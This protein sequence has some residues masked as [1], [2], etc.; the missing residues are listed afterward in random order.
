MT[1][2]DIFSRS[3]S[4]STIAFCD[5]VGSDSDQE[6]NISIGLVC[7]SNSNHS[8]LCGFGFTSEDLPVEDDVAGYFTCN[9]GI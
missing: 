2:K 4:S 3:I 7:S 9:L 5:I 6:A 8:S 1:P